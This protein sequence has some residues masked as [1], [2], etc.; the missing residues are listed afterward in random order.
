VLYRDSLVSKLAA[1]IFST[2]RYTPHTFQFL[3]TFLLF[4]T[5]E[6]HEAEPSA[7]VWKVTLLWIEL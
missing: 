7:V 4:Q 2:P 5:P 1:L 6:K 3:P